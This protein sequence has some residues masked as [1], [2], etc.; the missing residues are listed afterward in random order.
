VLGSGSSGNCTLV[1]SE[2]AALLIDAGLSGREICGRLGAVGFRLEDVA[3]V[4]LT[5][6]HSDHVSGLRAL[7]TRY[8]MAL[9]ANS[10]TADALRADP[11]MTRLQWRIFAT[12]AAFEIGE[13]RIEPFAVPHD[14]YDPVGFAISGHG[15]RVGVVTDIGVATNLV[16]ER[17]RLCH[18]LIIESNHDEH[19]LRAADRPWRLKQRIAGRQGHLSN[20][21]AADLIA[22]IAEPPLAHVF[23]SHL[24]ADCNRA[25]VAYQ[26]MRGA[27]DAKG[28][29]G[30]EVH[31]SFPDRPSDLWEGP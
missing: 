8:G 16:R 7:Q 11:A 24:S 23:L 9:Y 22:S 21:A 25:D 29:T 13:L 10:A 19:L 28:L 20:A 31:L 26:T 6:E 5:H 1:A 14:A 2:K 18:A 17:L 4:C 27:L 3:A 15:A 12:G 30:I